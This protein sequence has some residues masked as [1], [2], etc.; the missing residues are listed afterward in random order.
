[1]NEKKIIEF[2]SQDR[3]R[4]KLCIEEKILIINDLDNFDKY[5]CEF[6]KDKK[7]HNRLVSSIKKIDGN[8]YECIINDNKIKLLLTSMYADD[9]IITLDK[10][11][12][13]KNDDLDKRL[14]LLE[15]K[16]NKDGKYIPIK[17]IDRQHNKITKLD[18]EMT[19]KI[20]E[21]LIKI[22][23]E[24]YLEITED[25]QFLKNIERKHVYTNSYYFSIE[26]KY[27]KYNPSYL[28]DIDSKSSL[29]IVDLLILYKLN[30]AFSKSFKDR[31][32]INKDLKNIN[33]IQYNYLDELH[34]RKEKEPTYFYNCPYSTI[35]MKRVLNVK[36]NINFEWLF[37]ALY[38]LTYYTYILN[39][40]SQSGWHAIEYKNIYNSHIKCSYEPKYQYKYEA[41]ICVTINDNIFDILSG[42]NI[43][44]DMMKYAWHMKNIMANYEKNISII[45][46]KYNI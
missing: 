20:Q 33:P 4:L 42:I 21:Y 18:K 34:T 12:T 9:I 16:I 2:L 44:D 24:I 25:M 37:N 19:D 31:L 8:N 23:D 10:T 45:F 38:E 35:D 32:L 40:L 29:W 39:S 1:M 13:D 30:I 3:T 11:K 41:K 15:N 5:T 17:I 43:T 14:G 22:K 7:V 27:V 46:F 28:I 6:D 26:N 36:D